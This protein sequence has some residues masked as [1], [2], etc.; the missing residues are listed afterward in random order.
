MRALL[1]LGAIALAA[2]S[3]GCTETSCNDRDPDE[4]HITT[5]QAEVVGDTFFSGPAG[6]P[7]LYFPPGRTYVFEHNW[8][9]RTDIDYRVAFTVQ[10][11]LAQ[12]AGDMVVEHKVKSDPE[13]LNSARVLNNTCSDFWL[14]A[15]I[16]SVTFYEANDPSEQNGAAGASGIDGQAGGA[17]VAGE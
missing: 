17:G 2:L 8:N 7:Y 13:G 4:I 1:V 15:S 10:G 12:A 14:Y 5:E 9:T 11:N 6:G 16:R 3:S